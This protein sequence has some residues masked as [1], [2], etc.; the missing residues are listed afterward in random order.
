M[1]NPTKKKNSK[2]NIPFDPVVPFLG[3]GPMCS[4]SY[5]AG[6]YSAMLIAALFTLTEKW[7]QLKCPT[8]DEWVTKK[9]A[10][11]APWQLQLNVRNE[12]R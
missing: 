4:T 9:C 7:K 1:K 3:I 6:S 2:I 8:V 10:T 11:D 12:K 5:S